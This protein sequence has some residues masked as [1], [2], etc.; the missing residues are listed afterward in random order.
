MGDEQREG[1][2]GKEGVDR[3][4]G[5]EKEDLK[6][7]SRSVSERESRSPSSPLPI[8]YSLLPAFLGACLAA[9][10]VFGPQGAGKESFR[11]GMREVAQAF[12]ATAEDARFSRWEAAERS[13]ATLRAR[14]AA[15]TPT[16]ALG[17]L[18]EERLL[19]FDR[20]VL[21]PLSRTLATQD[22]ASVARKVAE[23]AEACNACHEAQGASV[24]KVRELPTR[25]KIL[26]EAGR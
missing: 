15:L 16:E 10:L 13:L 3:R 1:R 25:E 12:G 5:L 26:E 14:W 2:M 7:D 21:L 24:G 19:F 8:A 22:A 18:G 4:Q 11:A 6:R 20:E 17:H 23:V 9:F